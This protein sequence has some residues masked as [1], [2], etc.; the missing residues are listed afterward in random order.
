MLLRIPAHSITR[1]SELLPYNWKPLASPPALS[2]ELT[3]LE[4]EAERLRS[5]G[6]TVMFIAVDGRLAGLLGVADPIK[7]STKEAIDLLHAAGVRITVLTG[8]SRKTAEVVARKLGI[9]DVQAEV[10]PEQKLDV[11]RRVLASR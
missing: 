9:D 2:I 8:D 5:E 6:Q 10:L 11:V 1:L 4:P 7:P 3:S